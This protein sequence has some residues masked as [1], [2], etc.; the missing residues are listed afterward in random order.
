MTSSTADVSPVTWPDSARG[1]AFAHWLLPLAPTLGLQPASLRVASADASFRRYLRIDGA[2]DKHFILMDAPPPLEDV[3]PFVHVAGLMAAC[4]L[5]APRVLAADVERG[6]LLLTDLGDAL[7]L[8]ALQRAQAED[9]IADADALMRQAISSLVRWQAHA[10]G[11]QLPPY[12]DVLLRR[13]LGLFPTWCLEKEFGRTWTPAEQAQWDHACD[14]LV[15]SALAQPRVA[16]HRDYM[17]RNLMVT[18]DGPGILDF[19]DAV[20]GPISYDVASLMRDAF[21]S[22][23]EAQEIDWAVRYWEAAKREGLPV[24]ADFGEFWRALEWMGLQRHLKVLGI[25][26]R[27]KHRD[28]K[29]RYANDLPRFFRYAH[30]VATR[31]Q[32][33]GPLARLLEPL[34]G[35]ARVEVFY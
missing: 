16:V 1:Q 23:D 9:R 3:R 19:Q 31:Y 30:K 21:I 35:E 17:P 34:M 15:A 29:A 22:W 26:C 8:Q 20:F 11:Q 28:G 24:D 32:G 7:Y 10:E 5:H 27:L 12:D 14:L 6:F 33:L 13:E 18:P 25:F 4:Q 2:G